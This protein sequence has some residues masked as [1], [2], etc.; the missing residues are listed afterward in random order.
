MAEYCEWHHEDEDNNSW[1]TECKNIWEL[2][3]GNPIEN[4]MN[5]CPFCGRLLTLRAPDPLS[6]DEADAESTEPAGW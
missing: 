6:A 4:S 5:Y 1:E 2:N 3:E